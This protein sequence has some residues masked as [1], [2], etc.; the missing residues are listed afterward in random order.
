ME[1]L[2]TA[3][4]MRAVD[5]AVIDTVGL[6]SQV[7]MENAGR[8]VAQIVLRE[9]KQRC[10]GRA[11]VVRV[12]CGGGQN[13][14]DGF[15]VARTLLSYGLKVRVLCAMSPA[16]LT[17]DAKTFFNVW[18]ALSK[19]PAVD[20]SAVLTLAEWQTALE[21]TDILV[22]AIFGTGLRAPPEDA[23]WAAI[24]AMNASTALRVSIDLPS[25]LEADTG[26]V[27]GSAVKADI[28][29]TI[30]CPKRGLWLDARAEVG[31]IEVVDF[32]VSPLA[33][34]SAAEKLGPLCWRL[35]EPYV[36]ERL[37]R[38]GPADH[39]GKAGHLLLIAGSVGKTGAAI[40]AGRAAL[41]AG[42]GLVTIA[43]T[44]A[45]QAALDA[46]VFAEMT[47]SYARED[48]A[49]AT[50]FDVLV[51][52]ASTMRATIVGPGSPKGPGMHTLLARLVST[53]P[54]PLV[55]DADSLTMLATSF[56]ALAREAPSP[57]IVT[58]HP[59][60]MGRLLGISTADVEADR[61]GHARA[62]AQAARSVVVLKGARTIVALPTGE[63]FVN[64]HANPA[65]GT[66]GSGDV[67]TGV[68]GAFLTQ[69]LSP[70][71]AACVAVFIHGLSAELAIRDL[72]MH[73]LMASDLP[74][75]VGRACE[76]LR[77][78]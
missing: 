5:R 31:R 27:L 29:A 49:D 78:V 23:A 62:F 55:L 11:A 63:A 8:G 66:A 14:G 17:G 50:S 25:G 9:A 70:V 44:A 61:L 2:L 18:Q 42:A 3:A 38:R 20:L 35:D 16:K 71:D 60:E 56:S 36:A 32:G 4:Q 54:L 51:T 41:R 19:E 69:G 40:L 12:I 53:W 76:R 33:V 7:L 64:P 24:N 73:H 43:S 34:V 10:P 67:L 1:V 47:T 77:R 48:D 6:P 46:K 21:E 26:R 58:P 45:G 15:V 75:A 52:Q 30:A 22:D 72:G 59:G 57:R 39:K 68:I 37:P 65:L 13:G 28:T 74:D